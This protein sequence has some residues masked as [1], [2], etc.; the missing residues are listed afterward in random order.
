VAW[1]ESRA[2]CSKKIKKPKQNIAKTK[3]KTKKFPKINYSQNQ[4]VYITRWDFNEDFV[5][6]RVQWL[7]TRG[8]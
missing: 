5:F 3:L 6:R 7:H 4:G 2:K 8:R 1:V